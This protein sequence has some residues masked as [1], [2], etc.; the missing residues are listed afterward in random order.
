MWGAAAGGEGSWGGLAWSFCV[1]G[2]CVVGLVAHGFECKSS[3]RASEANFSSLVEAGLL[4][5]R[6]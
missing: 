1:A 6:P 2:G 3:R 4:S 5:A